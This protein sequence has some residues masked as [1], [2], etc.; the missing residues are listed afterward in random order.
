M[1]Q[2][3][4]WFDRRITLWWLNTL[5]WPSHVSENGDIYCLLLLDNCTAHHIDMSA[6]PENLMIHF[7]LP[8]VTNTHQPTD[9]GMISTLTVGCKTFMLQ[10]V[11]DVEGGYTLASIERGK[12]IRGC[13]CLA[14]GD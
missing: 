6:L 14:F 11:V 1:N 13:K 10:K 7:L 9:M 8:N 2:H 5:F 3:N 12:R 4:S